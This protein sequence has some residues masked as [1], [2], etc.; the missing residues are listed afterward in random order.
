MMDA[1]GEEGTG[2]SALAEFGHLV[3]D[4]CYTKIKESLLNF[5]SFDKDT[6]EMAAH[7]KTLIRMVLTMGVVVQFSSN[8][9]RTR[10]D[11][12]DV[13][14]SVL[15]FDIQGEELQGIGSSTFVNLQL[16]KEKFLSETIIAFITLR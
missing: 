6:E 12:F 16:Q 13:L 1:I 14:K 8:L 5:E 7:E 15:A 10:L 9:M 3:L 2:S 11:L 4:T